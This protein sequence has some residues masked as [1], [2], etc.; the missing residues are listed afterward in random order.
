MRLMYDSDQ[1]ATCL[2]LA[3]AG[4]PLVASYADLV[5]PAHLEAAKAAGSRLLAIDRG[6]GDPH[7]LAR[8]GD[9]E[10]GALKPSDAAGWWDQ[11]QNRGSLTVYADRSTMPGLL[12]ALGPHRPVWRWWA[13]LDGTMRIPVN[14]AAMVQFAGAAALGV[15]VPAVAA[16]ITATAAWLRARSA[17]STAGHAADSAGAA[18]ERLDALGAVRPA[19]ATQESLEQ[20]RKQ[21]GPGQ[22]P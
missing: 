20:L 16:L 8:I 21:L 9:F 14:P 11:H 7:Q 18:H 15:L 12:R 10:R 3:R 13:T 1:I 2:E 22:A 5:T 19:P 17:Q 4:A 6:Q